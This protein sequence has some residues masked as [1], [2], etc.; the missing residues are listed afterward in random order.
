METRAV[1]IGSYGLTGR[2][3]VEHAV[4]GCVTAIELSWHI[5][6]G[7]PEEGKNHK[8]HM[9]LVEREM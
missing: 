7:G 5:S 2:K 9:L 8:M 3:P 4:V 1:L 6:L